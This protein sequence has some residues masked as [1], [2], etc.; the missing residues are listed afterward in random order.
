MKYT[1]LVVSISLFTL[2]FLFPPS[3]YAQNVSAGTATSVLITDKNVQNG[4]IIV[5]TSNGYKLSSIAY[6][7]NM[8]GVYTQSPAI[9]LQNTTDSQSQPVVTSGKTNVLVSSIGGNI[10]KNDLITTSTI[11]GVGQKATRNG[12]VLGTALEDYSNSNQKTSGEILAAINPHYNASFTDTKTNILEVLRNASDLTT[13]GQLT[14]L[15]YVLAAGIALLSFGIGFIYFGRVTSSG[16]EA[17]GRNPLASRTIQLN[18]ILN[19]AFMV[20]IIVAGLTIGYLIL[21]L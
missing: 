14:S 21:V 5:T 16:V 10:K 2:G 1:A 12:M 4:N 6:D 15:R 17:L 9:Y 19:L 7:T 8:Y 13:L 3:I 18:L 20:I 11:P